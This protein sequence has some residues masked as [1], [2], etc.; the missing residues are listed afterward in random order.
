MASVRI[1]AEHRDI[2]DALITSGKVSSVAG[3]TKTGPFREQRD[4]YVFAA[5][6]GMALR[7]PTSATKMPKPKKEDTPIRDSVFIGAP[8]AREV[9]LTVA[10]LDERDDESLDQ[11]L[12]RQLKL[13]TETDLATQFEILD[14]YAHAGFCWLAQLQDDESSIR[15][16]ILAAVDQIDRVETDITDNSGVHDPLLDMLNIGDMQL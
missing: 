12:S 13:I 5:S 16:L 8:G 3:A 15:D 10:L 1:H 2:L 7:S 4:A 9:C 6:I 14:R 11:S